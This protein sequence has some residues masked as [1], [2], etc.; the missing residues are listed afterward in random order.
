MT[1]K[2][3]SKINVSKKIW[4]GG[5][6]RETISQPTVKGL[7]YCL[8]QHK[9][10]DL[11]KFTWKKR[12]VRLK[13][14]ENF[15]Q[16]PKLNFDLGEKITMLGTAE[17]IWKMFWDE[18]IPLNNNEKK[19]MKTL[20]EINKNRLNISDIPWKQLEKIINIFYQDNNRLSKKIYLKYKF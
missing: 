11:Y 15:N 9:W 12:I 16:N 19:V 13:D 3:T 7:T 4:G 20:D 14:S 1:E 17:E 18:V 10:K 8:L 6:K 5:E 2:I